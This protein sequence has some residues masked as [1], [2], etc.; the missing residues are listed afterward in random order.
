M[1]QIRSKLLNVLADD[2]TS[3]FWPNHT[4]LL[5]FAI[6]G[7]NHQIGSLIKYTILMHINIFIFEQKLIILINVDY[8]GQATISRPNILLKKVTTIRSL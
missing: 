4:K 8:E 2:R 6:P 1:N 3:K 5:C 7:F